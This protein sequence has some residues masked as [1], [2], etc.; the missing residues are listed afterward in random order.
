MVQRPADRV[1]DVFQTHRASRASRLLLDSATAFGGKVA[2]SG[3]ASVETIQLPERIHWRKLVRFF[4]RVVTGVSRARV[5]WMARVISPLLLLREL[6]G[7]TQRT[8]RMLAVF[9]FTDTSAAAAAVA[10]VRYTNNWS[11]P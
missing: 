9:I 2:G 8:A 10:L 1:E 11:S 3:F 7:L 4:P 6:W 5:L